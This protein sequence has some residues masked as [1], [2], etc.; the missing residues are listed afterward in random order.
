MKHISLIVISR[1]SKCGNLGII[2]L[3]FNRGVIP[4]EDGVLSSSLYLDNSKLKVECK[5]KRES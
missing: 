1:T 3:S 4:G 2:V 5:H